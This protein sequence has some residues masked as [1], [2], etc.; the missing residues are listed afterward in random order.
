MI[1]SSIQLV[2]AFAEAIGI[3]EGFHGLGTLP[4]RNNNPGDLRSWSKPDG[5]PYPDKDGMV[6][7][8][9]CE[10][11][12]CKDQD[13]PC[14]IGWQALRAQIK[15]NVFKRNLTFFEFFA[16]KKGVYAGYASA[17]DHN[18]PENYADAVCEYVNKKLGLQATIG[19]VVS[20]LCTPPPP[21]NIK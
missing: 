13:H 9:R 15:I 6:L 16:G 8:P 7:F 4:S 19:D 17:G 21:R 3:Q 12:A 14:E 10:K 20:T 11:P 2:R 1:P 18:D 5:T